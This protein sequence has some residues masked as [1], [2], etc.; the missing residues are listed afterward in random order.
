MR[1]TVVSLS[2]L[3]IAF[4]WGY[5]SHRNHVFPYELLQWLFVSAPQPGSRTVRST[6][7]E[8]ASLRSLPY[9]DSAPDPHGNESGVLIHDKTR[10]FEGYTLYGPR[11]QPAAFLLNMDGSVAWQWQGAPDS[12]AWVHIE[13]LPDGSL[14]ANVNDQYVEKLDLNSRVLWRRELKAHHDLWVRENVV[15]ALDREVGVVPAVHESNPTIADKITLLDLD[16]G[17]VLREINLLEVLL[18]SPYSFLLR[19][20]SNEMFSQGESLDILHTNHVEVFDGA[21]AG[22]S[23]IFRE[24]NVLISMRNI[25]TIAVF[26]PETLSIEWIWGPSNLTFQHHPTL[27]AN[28]NFLVFDN[29]LKQSRVLELDPIAQKV[30]WEYTNPTFFS[31]T[32]GSAQRLPNAN[33]LITESDTGHVFE[34]TPGG[35]RVWEF[36]NPALDEQGNR[37]AIWRATRFAA[38]EICW[39]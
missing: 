33:T 12:E 13:L 27:L 26:D 15:W 25:N 28:G 3:S 17:R 24:G 16:D 7:A 8:L 2:L 32:R 11:T 21:L 9:V 20:V 36:S 34:V 29:G 39:R 31:K 10:A 22:R 30:V 35:E 14:L 18:N 38:D 19:A 23:R 1:K 4:V 6:S 37:A 5:F